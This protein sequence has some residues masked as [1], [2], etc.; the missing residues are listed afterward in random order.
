[1]HLTCGL[2]NISFGMPLRSILNQAFLA[3]A[4]QSGMDAAILDPERRELKAMMMAA[5]TLSWEKTVIV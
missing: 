4:I 5:E 2:S 3:L 1:M